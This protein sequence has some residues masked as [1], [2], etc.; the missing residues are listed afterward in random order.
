MKTSTP[1]LFRV[2]R[3]A[4]EPLGVF[5][6]VGKNDH[7]VVERILDDDRLGFL[8]VV[9]DA[10]YATAQRELCAEIADR[11]LD[12]ILDTGAMEL[13]TVVATARRDA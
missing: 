1:S 2:V 3:E 13:A 12:A 10:C 11:N 6:R 7:T 8:G 9:F 4:E 5:F